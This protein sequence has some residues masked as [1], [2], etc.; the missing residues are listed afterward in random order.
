[1]ISRKTLIAR[2]TCPP[3]SRTGIARTTDQRTSPVSVSMPRTSK[4]PGSVPGANADCTN[5]IGVIVEPSVTQPSD[6]PTPGPGVVT[7]HSTSG[8]EGSVMSSA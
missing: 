7:F 6:R 1:M 5:V 2:E 8:S 4:P 3:S